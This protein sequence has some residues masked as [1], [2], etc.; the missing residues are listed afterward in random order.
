M[1]INADYKKKY[2]C[3]LQLFMKKIAISVYFFD[4]NMLLNFTMSG[5]ISIS[6]VHDFKKNSKL[7]NN[8]LDFV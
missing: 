2:V 3:C 1:K 4:F 6:P 5:R 8:L 7:L